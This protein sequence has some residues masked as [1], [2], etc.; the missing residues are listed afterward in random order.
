MAHQFDIFSEMKEKE[1]ETFENIVKKI[2]EQFINHVL[3]HRKEKFKVL[4]ALNL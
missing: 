3:K 2:H 4:F 1:I